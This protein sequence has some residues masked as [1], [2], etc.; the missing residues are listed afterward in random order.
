MYIQKDFLAQSFHWLIKAA[1]AGNAFAQ[2]NLGHYYRQKASVISSG[3]EKEAAINEAHIHFQKAALNGYILAHY[4]LGHVYITKSEITSDNNKKADFLNKALEAGLKY[5]E[6]C[7][8]DK[9]SQAKMLLARVYEKKYIIAADP[10][11]QDAFLDTAIHWAE[12]ADLQVFDNQYSLASLYDL[13][14][15]KTAES[16]KKLYLLDKSITL[17]I[18]AKVHRN[19]DVQVRLAVNLWQKSTFVSDLQEKEMLLQQAKDELLIVAE[20][21]NASAQ[22]NL[23]YIFKQQSD[24]TTDPKQKRILQ[25]EAIA[26]LSRAAEQN[27]IRAQKTLDEIKQEKEKKRVCALCETQVGSTNSCGR[28]R[29]VYYCCK[30]C[31]TADWPK[32]KNSC[33]KFFE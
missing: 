15:D 28:C 5:Y 17:L 18:K 26:W 7:P 14:I 13:K 6:L 32:H 1:E 23:G 31:Q 24:N 19:A 12:Q 27:N 33:T 3:Q 20:Q 25:R 8:I 11:E 30:Q 29:G 21:N 4:N 10:Q 16:E 9:K 22:N 2:N